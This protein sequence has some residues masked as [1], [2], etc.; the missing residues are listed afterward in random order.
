VTLLDEEIK[1]AIRFIKVKQFHAGFTEISSPEQGGAVEVTIQRNK[2]DEDKF[3]VNFKFV[4]IPGHTIVFHEERLIDHQELTHL[5]QEYDKNKEQIE[6][7]LSYRA[8]FRR[9]QF[10]R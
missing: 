1:K 4:T 8:N 9:Q 10:S 6:R 5:A 7:E 2:E 3:L